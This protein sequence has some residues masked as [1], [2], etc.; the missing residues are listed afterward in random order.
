MSAISIGINRGKDGFRIDDFVLGTTA[1]S[2]GVDFQFAYNT[3]DGNSAVVLEKDL[4]I[5]L[6]AITL[7]LENRSLPLPI[8]TP[9]IGTPVL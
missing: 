9:W 8:G 3:T 2:G 5:A 1:P 4:I 6:K 7:A